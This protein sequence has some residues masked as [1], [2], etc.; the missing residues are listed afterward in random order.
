MQGDQQKELLLR[1]P[2]LK[3]LPKKSNA[4][5]IPNAPQPEDNQPPPAEGEL[6]NTNE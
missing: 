2:K 6:E 3:E 5:N 4:P 1:K